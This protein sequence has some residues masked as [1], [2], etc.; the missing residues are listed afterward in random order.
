MSRINSN[1]S[2][3]EAYGWSLVE[4]LERDPRWRDIQYTQDVDFMGDKS[5]LYVPLEYLAV[6]ADPDITPE[7]VDALRA[8][9]VEVLNTPNYI[10]SDNGVQPSG[11]TST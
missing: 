10:V 5:I 1:A 8:V 6:L 11:L 4:E 2:A 7:T 9:M 3:A